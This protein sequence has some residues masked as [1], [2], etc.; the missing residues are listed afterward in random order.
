MTSF[1][2]LSRYPT[3]VA[4]RLAGLAFLGLVLRLISLTLA[5]LTLLVGRL[6]AAVDIAIRTQTTPRGQPRWV[7]TNTQTRYTTV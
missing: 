6:L 5:V 2:V 3:P 1:E 4:L 7:A